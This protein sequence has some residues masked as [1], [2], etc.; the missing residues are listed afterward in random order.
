M[1]LKIENKEI[2]KRLLQDDFP[3][4]KD[5]EEVDKMYYDF[6]NV[7]IALVH[8]KTVIGHYMLLSSRVRKL[9]E[10]LLEASFNS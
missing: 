4:I 1:A 5:P 3:G 8:D 9:E 2:I 6:N 10:I 7:D